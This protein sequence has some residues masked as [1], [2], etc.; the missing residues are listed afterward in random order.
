MTGTLTSCGRR[1]VTSPTRRNHHREFA[2]AFIFISGTLE[3]Q[4]WESASELSRTLDF[5]DLMHVNRYN[6]MRLTE[7][8]GAGLLLLT[9]IPFGD[10]NE[11]KESYI[12]LRPES[13][14]QEMD[15]CR[16]LNSTK[17]EISSVTL[18]AF[19]AALRQADVPVHTEYPSV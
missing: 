12:W 15:F 8:K 11:L 4:G 9:L 18:D 17:Q 7:D 5:V 14:R 10:S 6:L 1:W 3:R 2:L 19:V 13:E 16:I